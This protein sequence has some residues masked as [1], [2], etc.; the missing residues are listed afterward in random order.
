[1]NIAI[2][3]LGLVG[4][5]VAKSLKGFKNANV[6]GIDTNEKTLEKAKADE[7]I[8]DGFTSANNILDKIDLTIICVYPQALVKFI[9]ENAN[10]FKP[11]SI[12]LDMAGVK[13]YVMEAAK[14]SG[15]TEK[16]NFIGGH[17]MAGREVGGY[18]N[19]L[20]TL[21][22]GSGFL[23]VPDEN[24]TTESVETVKDALKFMGFTSIK[25]TTA[26]EHDETIAFTSQILHVIAVALSKNE[27]YYSDKAFKGGSFRDYTRIALINESL[28]S[29]TLMENR[30][31]LLKRID[32]FEEEIRIIKQVLLD[33]DK[34]TLRNILKND[35]LINED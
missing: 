34:L 6:F 32:E 25:V 26:R 19:S 22:K 5:S 20:D 21:F 4:G 3:G 16:V 8:E 15:I 14:E 23:I 10:L 13:E 28:W 17:P 9:N 29:E 24:A 35:R 18:E 12:V 1:M 7:V 11:G 30:K 33:G 2:V 31:Y 27:Y